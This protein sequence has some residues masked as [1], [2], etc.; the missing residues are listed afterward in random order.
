[1]E[2]TGAGQIYY[3]RIAEF[4]QTPEKI[5]RTR[6]APGFL[7]LDFEQTLDFGLLFITAGPITNLYAWG[8]GGE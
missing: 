1:M 8:E 6:P 4:R 3:Q 5:I 7:R 2:G